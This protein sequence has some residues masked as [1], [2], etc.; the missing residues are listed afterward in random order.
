VNALNLSIGPVAWVV[1]TSG[2][3][4]R[5]SP[6][7]QEEIR[8]VAGLPISG[9]QSLRDV[10]WLSTSRQR[11]NMLVMTV[12]GGSALMLAAV[13]IFGLIAYTVE[14]RT[15]E[16]GIRLALGAEAGRVRNMVVRQG[17]GLTLAGVAIGL[18][19]SFGLAQLL[20]SLLFGIEARDPLVFLGVPALLTLV[21]LGAVWIPAR[22][23]SRVDPLVALRS[24]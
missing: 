8:Q 18:M 2:D 5:L 1:R 16:I 9:V 22:R 4:D 3:A 10:V 23:A 20:S 13:G 11:F 6:V 24:E 15:H 14:Q 17:M 19:A 7:I 21:A 12:F